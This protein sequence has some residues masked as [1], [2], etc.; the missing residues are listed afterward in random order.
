MVLL[1]IQGKGKRRK[2]KSQGKG[3]HILPGEPVNVGDPIVIIPAPVLK[4]VVATGTVIGAGYVIS[5]RSLLKNWSPIEIREAI[6]TTMK[7]V[8]RIEDTAEYGISV[9]KIFGFSI[10]GYNCVTI[11]L[12]DFSHFPTLSVSALRSPDNGVPK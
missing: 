5:V 7:K 1:E 11:P 8:I 3:G 2:D 9:R 12:L 10:F 4:A 6:D